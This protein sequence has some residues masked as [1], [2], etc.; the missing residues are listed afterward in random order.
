MREACDALP[1]GSHQSVSSALSNLHK[2]GVV[3]RLTQTRQG[4]GVYV[5]DEPR[6]V[7]GRETVQ[8]RRNPPDLAATRQ[9]ISEAV[10]AWN[11][12]GFTNAVQ[13]IQPGPDG[14]LRSVWRLPVEE[15][16]ALT[17]SVVRSMTGNAPAGGDEEARP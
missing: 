2:A 8:H 16:A 10:L 15:V 7:L 6:F 4:C 17:D 14:R 13:V 1:G 5:L 9:A 3:T 11:T 12:E